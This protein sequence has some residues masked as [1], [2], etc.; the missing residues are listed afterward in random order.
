MYS[1]S[2]K[3]CAKK[4]GVRMKNKVKYYRELKGWSQEKLA[5]ESEVSRNTI[6]AIETGSNTNVTYEVM[7]KIAKAL[8]KKVATIFFNQ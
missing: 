5:E 7:E 2:T 8:D 1:A 3:Y 6:S 4:R